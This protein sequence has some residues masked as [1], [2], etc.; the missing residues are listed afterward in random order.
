MKT[1]YS[2]KCILAAIP[3][4]LNLLIHEL[5]FMSR[6]KALDAELA[7]MKGLLDEDSYGKEDVELLRL[8]KNPLIKL[9]IEVVDSIWQIREDYLQLNGFNDN[10]V[11]YSSLGE[12]L[13]IDLT[14]T[15]LVIEHYESTTDKTYRRYDDYM[16]FF[17]TAPHVLYE[18]AILLMTGETSMGDPEYCS[19][20]WD[21]KDEIVFHLDRSDPNVNLLATAIEVLFIWQIRYYEV[22]DE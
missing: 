20:A 12:K 10:G 8:M 14:E 3:E 5:V 16:F 11:P 6:D 1:K 22:A 18:T 17:E 9:S 21:K 15:F 19:V 13:A 2:R 7:D 4:I